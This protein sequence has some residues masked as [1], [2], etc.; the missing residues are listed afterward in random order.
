MIEKLVL[1][2]GLLF[3]GVVAI[4]WLGLRLLYRF[5][6]AWA[7][8]PGGVLIDTRGRLGILQMRTG[9]M[10]RHDAGTDPGGGDRGCT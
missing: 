8:G 1:N 7:V 2:G 9:H 4:R 10:H 3:L 6:P 5:A